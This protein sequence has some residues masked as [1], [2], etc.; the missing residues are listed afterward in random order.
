MKNQKK[1]I[2]QLVS[3]AVMLVAGGAIGYLGAQVG[4]KAAQQIPGVVVAT[5]VALLIRH[6]CW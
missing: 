3:I 4:V 1:K 2:S 5:L 6:S